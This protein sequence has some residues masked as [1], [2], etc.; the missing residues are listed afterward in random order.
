MAFDIATEYTL[1]EVL[2]TK[3]PNGEHMSAYD[4]LS[5]KYPMLEEGVWVQA[6]DNTS[7]QFLRFVTEPA[8]SVR[9]YNRGTS[10]EA[11]TT[12]PVKEELM[13]LES[14]LEID[15]RILS[16]APDPIRYRIER[17]RATVRGLTKTFHDHLFTKNN[18][19]DPAVDPRFIAGLGKRYGSL[20]APANGANIVAMGGTGT[21]GLGSI[22]LV[23]HGPENFAFLYPKDAGRILKEEDKGE[24]P[25]TDTVNGGTY[26]VVT[27]IWS[28]EFGWMIGDERSI[29][30]LCNIEASGTH[31]FHGGSTGEDK[32]IDLLEALPQG[33]V[34]NCAFYCGPEIMAQIR[35]RLNSKSNMY[36]T[37]Q[38]VWGRKMLTFMDVP[39]I[40]VDSLRATE[41][42]LT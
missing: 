6:N 15:T 21:T 39:L 26:Y 16:K 11:V 22:W 8:G 32:L 30:R 14:R 41:T 1:A 24:E 19:G 10:P 9:E 2:R 13:G 12:V 23:K 37:E 5:G 20:A 38:T 7:H 36:F 31:S 18:R 4:V 28:W 29:H 27:T 3:A 34:S 40:R 35:K 33:D 42:N 17:E 25:K